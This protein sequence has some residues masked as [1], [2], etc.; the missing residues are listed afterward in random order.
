M[1]PV[2][3]PI[4]L[5]EFEVVVLLAVLQLVECGQPAYGSTIR[6]AI[7]LRANRKVARGAIYVT[8]DRL[9]QKGLLASRLAEATRVRDH[10]PKRLFKLTG[11]GLK[12]VRSAVALVNRMQRGL[13]PVLERP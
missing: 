6:D 2:S 10:R 1:A 9:E 12:A 7:V 5:G 11:A 4:V 3:S 13:E 8:L